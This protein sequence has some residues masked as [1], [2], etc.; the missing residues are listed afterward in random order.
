MLVMLTEILR[1][2]RL[3]EI[4][5]GDINAA[6]TALFRR[7]LFNSG[8]QILAFACS[9]RRGHPRAQP[10]QRFPTDSETAKM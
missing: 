2:R 9:I 8:A 3:S 1:V 5:A 4:I 6:L 10:I 7:C